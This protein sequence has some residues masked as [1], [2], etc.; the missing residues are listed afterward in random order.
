MYGD[1][2]GLTISVEQ[3]PS[4]VAVYSRVLCV[5]MPWAGCMISCRHVYPFR[6]QMKSGGPN[7]GSLRASAACD[8][9]TRASDITT[10]AFASDCNTD[11][12]RST[13]STNSQQNLF[14]RLAD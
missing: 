5:E 4:W 13:S 12:S 2:K 3:A 11:L 14:R 8:A 9:I 10:L 7:S 1:A 6:R